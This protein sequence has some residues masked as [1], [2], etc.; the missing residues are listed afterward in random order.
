MKNREHVVGVDVNLGY[1]IPLG[2]VPHCDGVEAEHPRQHIHRLLVTD[3]NVHPDNRVPTFEQP[4]KLLNL[5]SLDTRVADKQDIHSL[6]PSASRGSASAPADTADD[7]LA[8]GSHH[9][10]IQPR[11]KRRRPGLDNI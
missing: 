7:V 8:Q 10:S 3:R 2:A 5:M 4:R 9:K 1:V 6:Q 11:P